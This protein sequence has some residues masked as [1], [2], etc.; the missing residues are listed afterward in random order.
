MNRSKLNP[1]A[2]ASTAPFG[3]NSLARKHT[4]PLKAGPGSF[5]R[6][7]GRSPTRRAGALTSAV[8]HGEGPRRSDRDKKDELIETG[9]VVI[10][11]H[12]RNACEHTR[13]KQERD[14]RETD[15][16]AARRTEDEVKESGLH[17][18]DPPR[19][20]G[21]APRVRHGLRVR[22]ETGASRGVRRKPLPPQALL[23]R[24]I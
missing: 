6:L 23:N 17:T 11:G 22:Y 10:P 15:W 5:K 19:C 2:G 18:Q 7:L 3:T 20:D 1:H 13:N 4:F 16:K 21:S 12:V 24:R 9:H 14:Y 8:R